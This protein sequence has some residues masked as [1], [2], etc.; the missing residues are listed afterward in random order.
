M[1]FEPDKRKVEGRFIPSVMRRA[2]PNALSIVACFLLIRIGYRLLMTGTHPA[3]LLLPSLLPKRQMDTLVY[4]LVGTVGI[5]AVFKASWPLNRMR[6]F[7]C[8]TMTAGFYAAVFLF[9][10]TLSLAVPNTVTLL[11]A[12]GFA[13][14]SFAVERGA[15][16]IIRR[17]W[18]ER[19]KNCISEAYGEIS[20]E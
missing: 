19:E 5:Q 14:L 11:L 6:V 4:L 2:L 17:F 20:K 10:S 8:L 13:L 18:P 9:G 15:A 12:C 7:L 3:A 1:S 16:W